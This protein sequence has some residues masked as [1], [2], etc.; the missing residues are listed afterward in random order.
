MKVCKFG[1]TSVASAQQ[2][3]KVANILL[4][5]SSR[6]IIVVSAPGKRYS[7][8][9]KV[10]DLLI[11]LAEKSLIGQDTEPELQQVLARYNEISNEL[12][13]HY[14]WRLEHLAYG[15]DKRCRIPRLPRPHP[16]RTPKHGPGS[17]SWILPDPHLPSSTAVA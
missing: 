4:S 1:G 10:T 12:V 9:T 3:K 15:V 2:I 16:S 6:K 17:G 11:L 13:A 7:D 5:D 8:D 14:R